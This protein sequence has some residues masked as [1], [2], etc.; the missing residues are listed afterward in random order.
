MSWFKVKKSLVR[1]VLPGIITIALV[2]YT[3][4]EEI[5]AGRSPSLSS[6]ALIHFAGYLFF[7][8][9]PVEAL[10]PIY[11][12]EG[13]AGTTLILIAV[14]TAIVAEIIDYCIG[15]AIS[16]RVI[17]DLIGEKR[18]LRF[19]NSIDKWGGWAI[20]FFNLFPLS[21]SVLSLVAGM[22]RYSARR[23]LMYSVAGLTL[24]YFTIVYFFDLVY[25][26]LS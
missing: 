7:L 9:M 22:M 11:Q 24:K 17:Y 20:L 18:Y 14:S 12:A 13:H 23:A 2:G 1:V 16:D 26:W 19:K 4:G 25:S 21:S 10:V 3:L 6:F 15:R 8:L 5:L